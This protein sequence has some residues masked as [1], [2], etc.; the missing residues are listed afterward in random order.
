M[1]CIRREVPIPIANASGNHIPRSGQHYTRTL[2]MKID[3]HINEMRFEL[4]DMPDT[5][6]DGYLPMSW[7]K[8]HNP[9]SNWE[10]GSLRWHSYYCTTH[11]LMVKRRLV[12]IIREELL[13]EDAEN[14]YL[15]RICQ[16]TDE[17]C[18]NIKLSLLPKYRDNADIFSSEMARALPK[19]SEH[20]HC[21]ELEEGK[22]PLSRLKYPLSRRELDALYEY[23][24]EMEDSGKI[25]KS[26]SPARAPILL[27]LKPDCSLQPCIDCR[28]LNKITIRNK[29]SLPL[30]N[31]LR[32]R[33][34]K[35]TVFTNLD[36]KNCYYLIRMVP[37]EEWKTAFKSHYGLYEYT[38]MP[39]GLYNAH[40]TFQSMINHVFRDM[41]DAGVIAYMN[42]ILIYSEMIEKHVSLGSQILEWLRKAE[43]CVSIKK[44]C[45]HQREVEFL[46]YMISE[47]GIS[48]TSKNVEY[49]QGWKTQQ[50]VE[51]I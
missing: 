35:A 24:R 6:V 41:L 14:I 31:K 27:V 29:Y 18:G 9:D 25:R 47:K 5:K 36:L 20:Y 39:L 3:N 38:V 28:G 44:S 22:V 37:V 10:K 7:L 50:S 12:L 49:N 21:I 42:N 43:L 30:M 2:R 34:S 26:S 40:S 23:I 45:F 32:N 19:H 1:P 8:D 11:C 48:M 4:A 13:A 51:D 16:H 33:L 15:L 46:E 17:Y